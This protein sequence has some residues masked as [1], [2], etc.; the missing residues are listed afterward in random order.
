MVGL[1]ALSADANFTLVIFLRPQFLYQEVEPRRRE[2]T[3][4]KNLILSIINLIFLGREEV[5][6]RQKV[7]VFLGAKGRE[8]EAGGN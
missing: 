5:D 1:N 3:L 2:E 4:R 8:Q 6:G 7:P